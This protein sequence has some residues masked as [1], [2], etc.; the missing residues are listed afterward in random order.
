MRI[1]NFLSTD[2]L[3][4]DFLSTDFLS[5]DFLSTDFLST[6]PHLTLSTLGPRRRE[7][8]AQQAMPPG[9]DFKAKLA[10]AYNEFF[11]TDSQFSEQ[12]SAQRHLSGLAGLNLTILPRRPWGGYLGGD[13]T[14]MVEPSNQPGP[15]GGDSAAFDRHVGRAKVGIRW[16]PGGGLF[17]W[18][19][20]YRL[21][22][23]VQEDDTF[24]SLNKLAHYLET[25]GR[26]TFLPRTALVYRGEVGFIRHTS[27]PADQN[28]LDPVRA[29]IGINGLVTHNF[30]VLA[31]AGWGASFSEDSGVQAENFDSVIG[32]AEATWYLMPQPKLAEEGAPV[33]LSSIALGYTRNFQV[34]S[35]GDYYQRDRVGL[36]FSYF[37][38]G[39]ILVNLKGGYSRITRPPSYFADR[40]LQSPGLPENRVDA[41]AFAEYRTSDTF[42]INTTLRY[43]A[44]LSKNL[45]P[46]SPAGPLDTTQFSR[47]EAYLGARF[48]Y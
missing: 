20:G 11:A 3:S 48:F 15:A 37:G 14:R 12:V 38:G 18:R 9:L 35:L 39:V 13:Y 10:G 47:F 26:W 1:G 43:N 33:G 7:G 25:N 4:T 22:L 45:V 29:M 23:S 21:R 17:Q 30:G 36:T 16:Q 31:M 6:T 5:S 34:A 28:D 40:T 44:Q 8:D 46:L 27:D 41:Q 19:F 42:G 32:Q 2:F 24:E